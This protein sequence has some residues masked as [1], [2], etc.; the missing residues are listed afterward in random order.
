[1]ATEYMKFGNE[2]GIA[3]GESIMFLINLV[4]WIAIG[5]FVGWAAATRVM[6]TV[7]EQQIIPDLMLAGFF[8]PFV[9]GVVNLIA[10][11]STDSL[12]FVSLFIAFAGAAL[13]VGVLRFLRKPLT[14]ATA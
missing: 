3:R 5:V 4:L 12:D 10:G 11:R 6:K 14:A 13:A 9:A 7:T 2:G 1:M 8:A